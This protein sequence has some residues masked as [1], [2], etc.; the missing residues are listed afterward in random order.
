MSER[1]R[2]GEKEDTL[3]RDK[4]DKPRKWKVCLLNDNYTTMEFV[5]F[6]LQ[7]VFHLSQAAATRVMLHI[8][9]TGIGVAGIYTREIAETRVDQ[10]MR[11]AREAGQPLQCTME[12]E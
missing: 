4:V 8:H 5:V 10:V 7:E 12:P 3:V 2:G 1:R 11:L 6:I 9:N